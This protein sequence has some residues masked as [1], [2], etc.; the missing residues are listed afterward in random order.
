MPDNNV[1]N[2][3]KEFNLLRLPNKSKELKNQELYNLYTAPKNDKGD[4]IPHTDLSDIPPGNVYQCDILYM[5]SENEKTNVMYALVIV[6]PS[7]GITDA[8]PLTEL[9]SSETLKALKIIFKRVILK[10]PK[11]KIQTDSGPEF[12]K[13]FRK[14][15]NDKGVIV[16]YGKAGRSRSQAF[17]E[18]R[19]KE[20]AKCL[21]M[22]MT[23]KEL[24]TSQINKEWTSYLPHVVKYL[25]R[26]MKKSRILSEQLSSNKETQE[27]KID[28]ETIILDVGTKVRV[29]LDKPRSVLMKQLSGYHFRATDIR[30]DPQIRTITKM[31][32][33][34]DQPVLYTVDNTNYPAYTYNQLQVVSDNEQA[35]P[36]S[37]VK[38]TDINTD[39]YTI[40]KIIEYKVVGKKKQYLVSFKGYKKLS[41]RQWYNKSELLKIQQIPKIREL[42]DKF[43]LENN[44]I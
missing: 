41:D 13:D 23:S 5:P 40:N 22:L 20:L 1:I 9:N 26:N 32:L 16:R 29:M 43:N 6:D 21:F 31:I 27:I 24:L 30:Y 14:Y 37:L 15:L 33:Q 10:M 44:I 2:F 42:I 28:D 36:A 4:E 39:T 34:P 7:S 18:S 3:Y 38:R 25:N 12:K 17:V 11:Y 8:E 35:P 19:N